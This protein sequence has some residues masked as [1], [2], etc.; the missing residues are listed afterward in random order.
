MKE[1]YKVVKSIELSKTFDDRFVVIDPV[2]GEVLD[3]AQ[4]YGYTSPQNAVRAY[5]KRGAE[6]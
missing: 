5:G 3:D 6:P 4:G 1:T 2:S